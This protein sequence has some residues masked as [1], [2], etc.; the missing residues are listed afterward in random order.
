MTKNTINCLN[1]AAMII[2]LGLAPAVKNGAK[3]EGKKKL[4]FREEIRQ[5]ITCKEMQPQLQCSVDINLKNVC[6]TKEQI[7]HLTNKVVDNLRDLG[8]NG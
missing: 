4:T 8:I 2:A 6:K 7:E 1:R 3:V 5:T